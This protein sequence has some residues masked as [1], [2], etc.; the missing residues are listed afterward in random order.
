MCVSERQR[1][2]ETESVCVY[3][4]K[5]RH[6]LCPANMLNFVTHSY[7]EFVTRSYMASFVFLQICPTHTIIHV[8]LLVNRFQKHFTYRSV[9]I[10]KILFRG[11]FPPESD[12]PY[13]IM[14]CW[15]YYSI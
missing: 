1:D 3:V 9:Q 15:F 11:F 2:R 13:K 12:P 5:T 4:V 7:M 14:R 8:F 10:F 6:H